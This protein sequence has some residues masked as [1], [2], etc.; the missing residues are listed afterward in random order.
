VDHGVFEQIALVLA[1]CVAAGGLAV[2]L[3][4]PLLVG[5]LIAGVLVGP[6]A[7]GLVEATPEVE[8][9]GE[10]GI[11]LLL[12]V[13]GLKLDPRLVRR[14]GPVVLLAGS[15]QVS[16]TALA[17]FGIAWAFG[18]DL[19]GSLY[20]AAAMA[21]SSTVIVVKMLTD[22]RE[23]EQL[24]GRIAVG[25]LIVQDIVVVLLMIGLATV[26]PES[27]IGLASQA[28]AVVLRG[29]AL[30]AI[31]FAAAR[32]VLPHV[33]P[34]LARQGELLVLASV[35]WAVVVA[36]LAIVLGFSGE[37]GAFLAGTALA[38]SEYRDAIS[39]RLSALRDFL[40]VF[41]FIDLGVRLELGGVED[42][43][44]V[45]ALS[46]FVLV[47][48]PLLVAVITTRLRFRARVGV[49]SGLTL[50]QISEFSLILVALGVSIG[51]VDG[52]VVGLV[53]GVA[54]VT[55]TASTFLSSRSEVFVPRLSP[56]LER[57]ERP[58]VRPEGP[59]A[60]ALPDPTVIVLGLGRL[61]RTVVT[62]LDESATRSCWA[63]TSIRGASSGPSTRSRSS[64][65]TPRTRS[66]P[67]T[68][69]SLGSAG[70]SAPCGTSTR[71]GRCSQP[72][73]TTATRA[74]SRS[75]STTRT[76]PRS[77]DGSAW[78]SSCGR[79]TKRPGPSWN[80]CART[81]PRAPRPSQHLGRFH[82]SSQT[83]STA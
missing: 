67:T 80:G 56:L 81:H 50:A 20:L 28:G 70:S 73:A 52:R 14:L 26:D 53:T 21:F 6:G 61:G 45:A 83:R 44:L 32:W 5:L 17:A 79:S 24:H 74:R 82:C 63:S 38:S 9:L 41:F 48:K 60:G 13:V 72:S 7:F 55:I 16:L 69:R 49:R 36:A 54:L 4:Q 47:G 71:T 42:L 58:P 15:I 31:V 64:T 22:R 68:Y 57:F 46:A 23:L 27:G 29:L 39:G 1:V 2:L 40:L 19:I 51:H 65:A 62:E 66:S 78:T 35:T 30:L 12:F 11:A 10:I 18:V 37:V 77:P 43:L 75:P 3:R 33:T 34:V 25:I 8:L 59:E 76:R